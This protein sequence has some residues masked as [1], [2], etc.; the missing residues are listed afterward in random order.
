MHRTLSRPWP[1]ARPGALSALLGI[2]LNLALPG[3]ASAVT[4]QWQGD[5]GIRLDSN[6]GLA[7][8]GLRSRDSLEVS[9]RLTGQRLL[10]RG[11]HLRLNARM[12]LQAVQ[13]LHYPRLSRLEPVIGVE[14]HWQHSA[15]FGAP[16]WSAGLWGGGRWS[17]DTQRDGWHL[18]LHAGA[19]RQFTTRLRGA[20]QLA[21]RWRQTQS[22]AFDTRLHRLSLQIDW[23]PSAAQIVYG[24]LDA[25]NGR[26]TTTVTGGSIQSGQT[27]DRAFD[28]AGEPAYRRDGT[29]GGLLLGLN[30][31]ISRQL[32]IDA[33][34]HHVMLR[35]GST[36]YSRTQWMLNLL[37]TL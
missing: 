26:F 21:S 5:H 16:R 27:V 6:A 35:R 19:Q 30:R 32:V 37:Y 9:Q 10:A 3:M 14:S 25:L 15:A 20:W 12:G 22:K 28:P 2:A 1:C 33:A 17:A 24:R 34:A 23:Q 29:G 7:A 4:W 31:Q 18:Q 13:A 8:D 11:S 36:G